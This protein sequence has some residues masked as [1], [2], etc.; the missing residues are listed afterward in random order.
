M[1][2]TMN[3]LDR[4]SF[5]KSSLL[6]TASLS[7]FP[8]LGADNSTK[9]K[10]QAPVASPATGANDDI[11]FAVVGFGGR[12]LDHIRGLREVKGA[13]M[14]ALCDVD[15]ATLDREVK[16]YRDLG[17]QI[18]SYTDIRKL[19][20][21]KDIDVVSFATPNHWHAL[22][23]I[24]AM[25]AG[26]D[27]YVEK[28]VSHNVWEGRQMVAAARKLNRI[29]QAGTQSR[30]SSG[31]TEG[32]Q[33]VREG[34]IGKILRARGL[35]YKRR[36]SIGKVDG[37]Q[38]IPPGIDYDLWCGP[39]PKGPLMRKKLHYDWHWVWPTGNGD[40]GNQGIHQMD[41]ARWVLGETAPSPRVFSVGGRLGY[42]DDGTTPNTFIVFHDYPTAPLI[43]EVRGLPA[44]ADSKS[45]DK[46]RGVDIGIVVDCEGGSMVIPDYTSAKILDKD[47]VEIKKF[48]GSSSHYANFLEAVRSRKQSDL[49]ADILEGHLSSALCHTGNISYRLGTTGSPEEIREALEGNKDLTEAL[50]H[51][52]QHLAANNVD[53]K[54]TPAT[55][56]AVLKMNPQ[57]ERFIDNARA[58][59]ML[60]REYRKPF[61][62][63]KSA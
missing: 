19:L 37:P 56:G 29:V 54:K 39:A 47:G 59:Q 40:L 18:E 5:L 38:P 3:R 17:E 22:G 9:R 50:G 11:R 26:K 31:I 25:Q 61:V 45:M 30:S 44:G 52:E 46:Y 12:G 21:N 16:K 41:M 51:M 7:L 24:W 32:I 23:S 49:H 27:V 4:R 10:A 55:L 6:T 8:A 34:H 35:C 63:P 60:T 57:T 62:V 58:D 53:L 1:D 42:V 43:F 13:R 48:K 2:K 15:R 20:E 36:P 14:V 33:W 28:P